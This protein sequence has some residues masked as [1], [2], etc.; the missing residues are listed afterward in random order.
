MITI[1]SAW[2]DRYELQYSGKIL[3]KSFSGIFKGS[4]I[5]R[6]KGRKGI[7]FLVD[8]ESIQHR[9]SSDYSLNI[10]FSRRFPYITPLCNRPPRI[11][12]IRG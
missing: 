7:V 3:K 1:L 11:N 2:A 6:W 12:L 9:L 4:S 10:C 5:V 8:L